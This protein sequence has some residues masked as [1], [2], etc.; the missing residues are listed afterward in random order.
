MYE[1]MVKKDARHILAGNE[2]RDKGSVGGK[3]K[4]VTACCWNWRIKYI[5][6]RLEDDDQLW[7]E[8][9]R[10]KKNIGKSMHYLLFSGNHYMWHMCSHNKHQNHAQT[11][12]TFN[13]FACFFPIFI[14][15]SSTFYEF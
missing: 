9:N 14:Y 5:F 10:A 11:H 4:R 2:K 7:H 15:L 3:T 1:K 6:T 13:I 12:L 8:K